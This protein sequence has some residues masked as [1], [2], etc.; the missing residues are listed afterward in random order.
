MLVV[1]E[2]G[3]V[4]LAGELQPSGRSGFEDWSGAWA[5]SGRYAVFLLVR[6]TEDVLASLLR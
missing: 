3:A 6:T 2:A 4:G 1:V 5:L